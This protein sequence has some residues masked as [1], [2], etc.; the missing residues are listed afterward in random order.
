MRRDVA[1]CVMLGTA[2]ILALAAPAFAQDVTLR[3][4]HGL[5]YSA[6]GSRL[7]IA[8]HHGIAVYSGGRWSKA[9][10]PAHDYMGFVVTREFIISSGH[11]ER[12]SNIANPLGLILSHDSAHSWTSVGIEGATDFHIVA[13]GHASSTVYVYNPAPNSRMPRRGIYQ[14]LGEGSEWR[15]ARGQGL[16]GE[17][18]ALAAH[19]AEAEMLAAATSAGL[20]L[21][22]D[23]GD[24][25][26]QITAGQVTTAYFTLEGDSLWFGIFDGVPRL[27]HTAILDAG[28]QEIT[29]PKMGR[30]AVAYIAQNPA[31]RAEFAMV[32]FERSV[33]LTPD[34]GK[35][36]TRIARPRGTL[37]ER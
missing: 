21:S 8:S 6:D 17:L 9:R 19:P 15:S 10:G 20:F 35:T 12:S 28:R 14:L 16:S 3:H 37:P 34:R 30:D 13:A 4:V 11:P 23:G 24:T 32:S 5:G 33:F 29:L 27:F 26:K 7:K 36:W 18:Y 22:Q 25:F 2:G 1:L 31:R